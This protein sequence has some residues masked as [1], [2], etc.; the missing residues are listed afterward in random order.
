MLRSVNA[1]V[2]RGHSVIV[3]EHNQE[4]IKAADWIIDL[5]PEGGEKGGALVFAGKPEDLVRCKDSYTGK[6][7]APRLNISI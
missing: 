3:I 1:L 2:D 7:L 6:F 5:G 4:V